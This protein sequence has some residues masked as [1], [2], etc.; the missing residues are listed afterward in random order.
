M[1]RQTPERVGKI[2]GNSQGR[3]AQPQLEPNV[4]SHISFTGQLVPSGDV[5]R[6]VSLDRRLKAHLVDSIVRDR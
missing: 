2:V 1:G 6:I 3:P 5:D 4:D